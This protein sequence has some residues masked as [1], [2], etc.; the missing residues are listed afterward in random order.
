MLDARR[1]GFSLIEILVIVVI[2]SIIIT[3][4]FVAFGDF[5]RDR[6]LRIWVENFILSTKFLQNK[7]ILENSL[8][9]I[10]I[11][12]NGYEAF[13]YNINKN[14]WQP[15]RINHYHRVKIV[16]GNKI[17]QIIQNP[18]SSMLIIH[19]DGSIK[20]FKFCIDRDKRHIYCLKYLT[21]GQFDIES[22]FK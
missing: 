6:K 15:I 17:Q 13:K 8:L 5:G 14:T 19:S 4:A 10:K 20:P 12:E 3:M 18:Q 1:R 11:D 7:A 22:A 21:Q 16:N 9:A 2:I